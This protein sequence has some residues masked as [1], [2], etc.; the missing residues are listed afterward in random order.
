VVERSTAVE[1]IYAAL[2]EV[3]EQAALPLP[4]SLTEDIVI[5]GKGAVLDSLGV[6]ALIV[7]VEQMLE[8]KHDVSITLASDKAM[9]A[10]NSPF[11]TVGVL[12][13]H[14]LETIGEGAA[15]G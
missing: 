10:K 14:V 11:R 7:D 15:H 3:L 1:I 2:Q 6:V 8:E 4:A 9:S 13:D 12:A 5:V